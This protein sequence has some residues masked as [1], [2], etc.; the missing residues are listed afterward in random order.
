ME[1]KA[2]NI[3][4]L[5]M[6]EF[7]QLTRVYRHNRDC[8]IEIPWTSSINRPIFGEKIVLIWQCLYNI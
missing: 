7:D 5:E 8:D 6:S 2:G 4:T 3:S 1:L